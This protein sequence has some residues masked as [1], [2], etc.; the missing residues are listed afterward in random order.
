MYEE[1]RWCQWGDSI[2]G[3]LALGA[4]SLPTELT[5]LPIGHDTYTPIGDT[6]L[7]GTMSQIVYLG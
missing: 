3:P 1:R 2:W 4:D 5:V 6:H 7:Q